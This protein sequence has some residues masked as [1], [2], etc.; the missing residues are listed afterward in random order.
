MSHI[1]EIHLAVQD[2]EALKVAAKKLNLEW[3]QDQATFRWYGKIMNDSQVPQ[4]FSPNDYGKCLHAIGVP[5]NSQAYEVGVVKSPNGK[6]WSL[7]YDAWQGGF[8][9]EALIGKNA[10][11]LK[12]RYAAEV[13]T[14]Q[15]RRQGFRVSERVQ[16]DGKIRL[17]CQR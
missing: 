15:A 13:A 14:K 3:R 5:G 9:L 6:G 8:G 2:L 4:G 16:A 7:L 1:A 17:V 11:K 12:Q 10:T